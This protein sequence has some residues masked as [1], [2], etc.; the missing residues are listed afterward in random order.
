MADLHP[1]PIAV[2]LDAILA[3]LLEASLQIGIFASKPGFRRLGMHQV[4]IG[5]APLVELERLIDF[6]EGRYPVVAIP[7][8]RE[9]GFFVTMTVNQ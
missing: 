5:P 7:S 2:E 3:H 1:N 6:C 9:A 4:E 8:W